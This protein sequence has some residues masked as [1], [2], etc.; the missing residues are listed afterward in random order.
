M[1]EID[2]TPCWPDR[3]IEVRADVSGRSLD[4]DERLREIETLLATVEFNG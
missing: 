2:P 3:W 4:Q 1:P